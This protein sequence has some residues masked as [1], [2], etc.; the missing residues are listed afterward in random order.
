MGGLNGEGGYGN[1]GYM[2]CVAYRVTARPLNVVV[3]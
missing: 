1:V 3:S 2:H